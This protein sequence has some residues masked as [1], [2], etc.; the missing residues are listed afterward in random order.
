MDADYLR[1]QVEGLAQVCNLPDP[2]GDPFASWALFDRPHHHRYALG[3]HW[4][5][6]LPVFLW[7][8]LNPSKAGAYEDDPTIRKIIGFT[9]RN[10]GGGAIVVNLAAYIATDPKELAKV[11]NPIGP[12]N[13][14]VL[15]TL[16]CLQDVRIVAAWGMGAVSLRK[17]IWAIPLLGCFWP[18][19][20]IPWATPLCLGKTTT[21]E[22]RHPG[23]I[24][25]DTPLVPYT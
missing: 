16:L 3:R 10:G 9:G 19:L 15:E 7:V 24:G 25:Y 23:R 1:V 18:T 20:R 5:W 14:T 6:S 22:P 21:G 13:I 4:N 2:E 11:K 17:R 12:N 8:L